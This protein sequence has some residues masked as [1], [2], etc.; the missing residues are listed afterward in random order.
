MSRYIYYGKADSKK[1]PIWL[2]SAKSKQLATE[3]FAALKKLTVDQFLN[4]YE[5]IEG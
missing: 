3:E 5:V 2:T 4:I 1:T